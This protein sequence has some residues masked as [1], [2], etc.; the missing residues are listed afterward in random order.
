MNAPF[1]ADKING[2]DIRMV[3][4]GRGPRFILE[5]FDLLLIQHRR[6][7]EDLHGHPAVERDLPGF[8]HDGHSATP[9]LAHQRVIAQPSFRVVG[10][11]FE[12]LAG[13]LNIGYRLLQQL[14]ALK[15]RLEVL[16][17]IGMLRGQLLRI[18]SEAALDLGEV[19]VQCL[20]KPFLLFGR[21]AVQC[22][23]I[24]GRIAD[25]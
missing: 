17:Q 8:V 11:L 21:Q 10:N 20:G 2:H 18:G 7:R 13:R 25:H 9:D 5:T 23:R 15:M 1:A 16:S 22:Q 3:Q 24:S 14:E 6:E 19:T 12:C 4:L